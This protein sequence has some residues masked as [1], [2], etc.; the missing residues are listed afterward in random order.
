[1]LTILFILTLM[2]FII[3]LRIKIGTYNNPLTYYLIF[4]G[5][6]TFVSLLNPYDLYDV[7]NNSYLL[8]WLNITVF[9]LGYFLVCNKRT[10]FKYVDIF[11]KKHT[12][13]FFRII[14]LIV[15]LYLIYYYIRYNFLLSGLAI[16]EARNIKYELGY[17]FNSYT[18][19]LIYTYFVT[20]FVHL[21]LVIDIANYIMTKKIQFSTLIT[22]ASVILF[23]L[24]GF[25]RFIFFYALIFFALAIF[26]KKENV[27]RIINDNRH[28]K[29]KK[30]KAVYVLFTVIGF[31]F[32]TLL[33]A[34]RTGG[35]ISD[36]DDLLFWFKFS[37]QEG[38][39]YFVGPYRA[40]DYFLTNK[41]Y[42]QI[43]FTLGR[44]TFSGIDEIINNFFILIGIEYK[45]ANG[46][47]SSF[48]RGNISI[49]DTRFFNAFY[50]G[51]V[52][53]YLDFRI[54][55][56]ILFPLLYGIISAK[57][58]NIYNKKP[59]IYTFSLLIYFTKTT[60]AYQYRWDFGA[61]STWIVIITLII[62][63]R[64]NSRIIDLK[65]TL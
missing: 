53:F 43:G 41:I 8:L 42:N 48:T 44:A 58:W 15:L 29:K 20:A 24:I 9:S 64:K 32:M 11:S 57:I 50:T 7:S 46:L 52:N 18:E 40:L 65:S 17:L 14:Q 37:I 49:G 1:M 28:N 38:V 5:G 34:N 36:F 33:T 2:M 62:L 51:I 60:I 19:Y 25:G 47:I 27:N 4:W 23:S 35:G 56:V 22:A 21:K 3:L 16:T 45:T 12:Q 59:N 31:Y 63:S 10:N 39:T 6:W 13:I 26:L 61:P 55:G 30:K 54:F